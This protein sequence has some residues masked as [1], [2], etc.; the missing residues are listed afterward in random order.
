MVA[1]A[2]AAHP[3]ARAV[4]LWAGAVLLVYGSVRATFSFHLSTISFKSFSNQLE[5]VRFGYYAYNF[6]LLPHQN[7]EVVVK[8]GG[9]CR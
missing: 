4:R 1:D 7:R 5:Q 9:D 8:E 6:A 2:L 3:V